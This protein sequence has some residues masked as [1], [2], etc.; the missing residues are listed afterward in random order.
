MRISVL[1]LTSL[2]AFT[3][4]HQVR[5][6]CRMAPL[7]VPAR[8]SNTSGSVLPH[9]LLQHAGLKGIVW[10]S[11]STCHS[12]DEWQVSQGMQLDDALH[13]Q[14]ERLDLFQL[15]CYESGRARL[16]STPEHTRLLIASA[17]QSRG[18]PLV[19]HTLQKQ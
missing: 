7:F 14:S 9:D 13:V 10:C 17:F 18:S 3:C 16:V 6:V 2:A 15:H 11:L 5:R 4:T 8:C 12:G 19:K 1:G